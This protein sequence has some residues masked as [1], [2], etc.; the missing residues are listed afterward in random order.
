ML[1]E[2]AVL[3]L[4]QFKGENLVNI[5]IE[6]PSYGGILKEV[7]QGNWKAKMLES[8]KMNKLNWKKWKR[9]KGKENMIPEGSGKLII[10]TELPGNK[11][12]W[13]FLDED[14]EQH[15]SSVSNKK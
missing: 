1:V 5:P 10:G 15:S 8:M 14:D 7:K 13:Q 6:L 12:Q 2:K 11:R 4:P 3:E 9:V